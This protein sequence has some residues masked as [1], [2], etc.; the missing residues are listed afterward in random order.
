[1]QCVARARRERGQV[2]VLFALLIPVFLML[3]AVV[4]G[5]GNWYT[6]AKH[7]QTKVD[8]AALAGGQVWGF[9]C[10]A[11]SESNA[12]GTGIVDVARD[13]FGSHTTA[14]G[15][16]FTSPYNPQVGGVSGDKVHVVI[17]GNA[18]WDD[19]AGSNPADKT[20]PAGSVC[21]AKTLDVK[22]TEA[23]S[24]PLA[25]ILPLFPDIKRKARL[26]IEEAA[27]V[28][29]LLPIAVRIP[30]PLSAAAV[31]YNEE[32]GQ[33]I[34]KQYLREV[35]IPG[36]TYCV[37]FAPAGLGQWTTDPS[38]GSVPSV[39]LAGVTGVA[40]ASSFRAACTSAEPSLRASRSTPRARRPLISSATRT[41]RSRAG[42]QPEGRAR[43]TSS[44]ACSSFGRMEIRRR[45]PARPRS[46]VFTS[47]P[48]R[49]A[50]HT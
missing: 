49:R 43:R 8:A 5:G 47:G 37:P 11:D 41:E 7:L 18:Y 20:S 19:D 10:G 15:A 33:I 36:V 26:Q 40:I 6:H 4:V 32:N 48:T 34:G 2:V 45:A 25:S 14:A 35:C 13:Y 46:A 42:T 22:A 38:S 16:P 50:S 23:N 39:A 24:F 28:T 1:M 17:N 9:P 29:G 31:F 12:Q 44:K 21:E 30:R 27:G 3:A